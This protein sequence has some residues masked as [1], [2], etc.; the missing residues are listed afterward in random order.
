ML[1]TKDTEDRKHYQ[2]TN[3]IVKKEVKRRKNR[4]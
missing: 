4:K 2:E 1:D 3:R